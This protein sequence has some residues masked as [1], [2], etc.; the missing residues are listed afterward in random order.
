MKDILL[1]TPPFTQLN[2]PYP[3]TAYLKG[4]LNTKGISS[5]Q[6]DLGIEVITKIFS[7]NGL[8][9]LFEISKNSILNSSENA[10][11]IYNLRQEYIKT[12]DA[13]MRFLQSK[14][15]SLARQICSGNF[16][17]EASRFAHLDDMDWAFG[18]MGMQDKAKHFATLYLEDL[19]DF[20]IEC[21]DE[22]FGFSRYAERLGQS[23]NSFDELYYELQKKPTYVDAISIQILKKKIDAI[24][25]KLVCFSVPFPGNLY[26]AFRC[27]Q[28]IKNTFPDI[29]IAMGGGF[30]NTELRNLKDI[31]VFDFFDFITLDDGELPIEL[32]YK[33][34][35]K[36][37][38]VEAQYKRTFLLENKQIIFQNNT[39]QIDYKQTEVG[40]P[41]YS[42][43][44]LDKYI[45]VIEV[46][47]PMHSLWSDGRWNKL[48]MAHGC[49]WGKCTFC[50]ISL[51]YIKIYE[52]IAAK[53][54]VDRMET[55]IAQ[56]NENGFHFVDEA[57][58]PA[59][60]REVAIEIIK[61]NLVVTWWTNIRFE[62]SFTRELCLLLKE[63]GCIA[64]SGGLEVASDRLLNLIKK[65]VTVEQVAQVTR[66][67][68]ETGI[69]VHAYLMYGFPTQ[70]I[71]ET[72][73]SLE[74]VR[75][76][77][78]IGVLQSGF[79]HQFAMTAHSPIGLN[80]EEF[81]VVPQYKDIQFANNDVQFIDKTRI[82]HEKFSFGLR[83][84]LYNYMH[85]ICFDYELQDW[86]DFKI[87]RTKISP[88]YIEDCLQKNIDFKI[89]P[90]AR[91]VF[92]GNLPVIKTIQ[93][94]KKGTT[95]QQMQL[96]F[97]G[98]TFD[99][100]VTLDWDKGNWLIKQFEKCSV[101]SD[102][103][104][105]LT[106]LKADYEKHFDDF[107]LFWF[108][109]PLQQLKEYNLLLL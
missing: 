38:L 79:W 42:D 76:L 13:V 43:L 32:L 36:A 14:N 99:Y 6:M 84:S 5:F 82:N 69:M 50:D 93:K 75:Q 97:Q 28:F 71:Q 8:Q 9:K 2:T 77:F 19:S 33:N 90:N 95:W 70:T 94:T 24:Q 96:N 57:A 18:S 44:L 108:S 35:C 54:I 41:D 21:I 73:D 91:I 102:N 3:A 55:M 88:N 58:P 107:E 45:S 12:I 47:N 10:S 34:I 31:R 87:P 48:T 11:R 83:K 80:P 27:A 106:Q 72:V 59:L 46:A 7:K 22:N 103:K 60:M 86:F 29:K 78:E 17:P 16:L 109:K 64:V 104:I 51:D 40:T 1:I 74:M 61:R 53:L 49:Y 66:N 56:T 30:P 68:T 23:A 52:P 26:S 4:F 25:P 15:P 20:I 63:S 98:K 37:E 39:P 85:G 92:I 100:S 62:K 65:G 67:F 101:F 89:K 81:G 105:T